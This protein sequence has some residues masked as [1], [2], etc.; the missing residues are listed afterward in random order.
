MKM[1]RVGI[2]HG[3]INGVGYEIIMKAL[4]DERMMELCTPVIFGSAKLM[5]YY[6]NIIDVIIDRRENRDTDV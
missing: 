3:D 5:A 4:S 6:R 2:T 1:I